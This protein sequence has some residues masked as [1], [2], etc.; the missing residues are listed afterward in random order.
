MPSM[1]GKKKKD[2]KIRV[3]CRECGKKLKLPGNEPGRVFRCPICSSAVV[4]PLEIDPNLDVQKSAPHPGEKSSGGRMSLDDVDSVFSRA[5]AAK[6]IGRATGWRPQIKSE[7]ENK[8]INDLVNFL[9]RENERVRDMAV[10]SLQDASA[11]AEQQARRLASLRKEKNQR[12]RAEIDQIVE[13]L[14]NEIR[15]MS[16][17][18]NMRNA[19]VR[20]RLEKKQAEKRE[21]LAYIQ[22]LFGLKLVDTH[23]ENPLLE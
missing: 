1:F 10:A 6:G 15:A 17:G 22:G 3:R 4:S 11:T 18:A 7:P 9:N 21:L 20:S 16:K 8:P 2:D 19:E 13:R 5:D 12:L 23:T 14:D